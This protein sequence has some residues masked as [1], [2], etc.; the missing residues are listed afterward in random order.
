MVLLN[1]CAP[2]K[3]DAMNYNDKIIKEQKKI[4]QCE[5]EFINA[6]KENLVKG[7]T[8]ENILKELSTQVDESKKI[9]D[10][11]EKFDKKTD[12]KDAALKFIAAYRD[13]V[14]NEYKAWLK[15]LK[16]PDELVT[17]EVIYQEDELVHAIN[18]KLDKANNEFLD[19][20]KEFAAKYK[21]KLTEK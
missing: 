11:L 13:A 12:F 16:I 4:V 8:L 19:A 18:R 3:Q 15:N 20:Q 9:I 21:F 10:G 17:D 7:A 5:K 2:T 6:V 1:S 14:D